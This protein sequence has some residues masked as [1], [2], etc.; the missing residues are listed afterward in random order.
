LP[1]NIQ[2]ATIDPESL[3]KYD[4]TIDSTNLNKEE[5]LS[6][7]DLI[8]HSSRPVIL[9]GGGLRLAQ[10][11]EPLM[12]FNEKSGIPLVSSL[13]GWTH[14]PT[15]M[16]CMGSDRYLGKSFSNLTIANS[17]LIIAL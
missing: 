4:H 14:F 8:L 2:R 3:E 17:D 1:L 7:I 6:V 13:N 10:V 12:E 9:V 5:F 11:E 16:N 15:I